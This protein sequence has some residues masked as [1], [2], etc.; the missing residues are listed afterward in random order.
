MAPWVMNVNVKHILTHI[1][2]VHFSISASILPQSSNIQRHLKR[3]QAHALPRLTALTMYT[4]DVSNLSLLSVIYGC[5]ST[6]GACDH[7]H[8]L[9]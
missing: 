8:P 7:I 1:V 2:G 9:K 4:M 6:N 3:Q 5:W